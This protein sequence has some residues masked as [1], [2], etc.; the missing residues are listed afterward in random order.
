MDSLQPRTKALLILGFFALV[1]LA[2]VYVYDDG[3]QQDS[4]F[5]FLFARW[6]WKYPYMFVGVWA[7]PLFT[8]LYGFPAL[9]G[10]QAAR[11][12]SVAIGLATAWQTYKLARDLKL[13]RSWLAVLFI[14]LQPSFFTLYPDLLTEP[15]YGLVF[16]IALRLHLRGR[17]KMGMFVASLMLMA[18]PEGFFHGILWGVWILFDKRVSHQFSRRILASLLL[19]SG[20][21]IWWA[22]AFIITKDPRWIKNNWPHE[23]QEGIYGSEPFYMYFLRLPEMV[24]P[25]MVIPFLLGLGLLLKRREMGTVTSSFLLLFLLHATFRTLGI[26]GDAGYP[27]YMVCVSSAMAIIALVGWNTIA[28]W[29]RKF[30]M[31]VR[32][33]TASLVIGISLLTCVLYMDGLIW[34][35]DAW[36]IK[37]AYNWYEAND[38]RPVKKLVWS[39]TY[40]CVLFDADVNDRS[41]LTN[42]HDKNLEKLKNLP[43]GTLV[44][45]DSE[46]GPSWFSLKDTDFETVGYKRLFTKDYELRGKII[47]DIKFKYGGVRKQKISLFYKE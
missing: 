9:I 16:V 33:A 11:L 43:G 23:W 6:G 40:M 3:F 5:H 14:F 22:I 36:A 28:D 31:P 38:K 39:H 18:R 47:P 37:D 26:L 10:Y 8:F 30:A 34:V 44:F 7:R 27:R 13:E 19:A 25:L 42:D 24:G 4:G 41:N 46:V 32:V 12:F 20:G 35:R 29:M 45:W 21:I 17:V 2:L 15:I 1:G